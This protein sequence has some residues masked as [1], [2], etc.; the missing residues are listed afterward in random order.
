MTE[1]EALAVMDKVDAITTKMAGVQ[2]SDANLLQKISDEIDVLKGTAGVPASVATRLGVLSTT[3]Q[4][5]SDNGDAQA[6]LLT[7]ILAKGGPP[8]P[9]TPVP[10]PVPT[11][12][13]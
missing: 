6:V 10:A 8:V 1:Q 2:T 3:L 11:P 9:P 7:G 4:S 12:A 5:L 13:P